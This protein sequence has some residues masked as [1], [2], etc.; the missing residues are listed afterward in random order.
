MDLQRIITFTSLALMI[1]LLLYSCKKEK[2]EETALVKIGDNTISVKDFKY[3]AEFTIRP[4]RFYDKN[5]V[6]NNL[7]AEKLFAAELPEDNELINGEDYQGFI[8]GIKE[9]AMREELYYHM[10]FN[11]AILDSTEILKN[12][13]M[14]G[15]EYTVQFYRINKESVADTITKRLQTRNPDDVFSELEEHLDMKPIHNIKWDDPD[16]D[17]IHDALF[18]ERIKPETIIGPLKLNKNDYLIMKVMDWKYTPTIGREDSQLKWKKIEENL[19]QKK[20]NKLWKNYIKALM[21]GKRIDFNK[22]V[23]HKLSD[24]FYDIYTTQAKKQALTLQKEIVETDTNIISL[25]MMSNDESF[26]QQRFFTID[27]NDYTVED[28]KKLNR[29]HPLVYRN[30]YLNKNDFKKQ[31]R[32]AIADLM[33][34]HYLNQEAYKESLD[35]HYKVRKK[36][37]TWEDAIKARYHIHEYMQSVKKRSDFNESLMKGDINYISI[38]ADSLYNKYKKSISI[39]IEELN[40]IHLTKVPLVAMQSRVPYPIAF[41]NFPTYTVKST[42]DHFKVMEKAKSE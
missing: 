27:N 37:T 16:A 14:S 26:L 17:I 31:F 42:I 36:V 3:R 8:K 2:I 29:S 41:P 6:L 12:Y 4:N 32:L 39:N 33:R 7:I 40:K 22:D 11:K 10:A 28:F 13:R 24:L 5:V 19:K 15:Y 34:D 21:K 20:A 1:H 35:N 23:F 18:S 38:Y 9:Q 30:K 25:K